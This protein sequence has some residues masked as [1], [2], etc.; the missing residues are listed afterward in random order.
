MTAAAR[1]KESRRLLRD[2]LCEMVAQGSLW[3]KMPGEDS[4]HDF[5]I[6]LRRCRGLLRIVKDEFPERD[7]QPLRSAL[8]RAAGYLGEV[9]DVDV[10]LE[11][12]AHIDRHHKP[13]G[14]TDV[15]VKAMQRQRLARYKR[16]EKLFTGPSWV[17]I[18]KRIDRLLLS[19]T[20]GSHRAGSH[21]MEEV[22]DREFRRLV[23]S[24][25]RTQELADATD[26]DS[27]HR[28]RTKL[29]RLRYFGRIMT[30]YVPKRHLKKIK[31]I[32]TCEQQLGRV[33][34]VDVTLAWLTRHPRITSVWLPATL[35]SVRSQR[36]SFFRDEWQLRRKKL[37][38]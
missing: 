12:V 14:K 18:Q 6:S 17:R 9:R 16:A 27:L 15:L 31:H 11:L 22:A 19:S 30:D 29:R 7:I 3:R 33:H 38:F 32:R 26:A 8:A 28:V 36:L 23:R 20:K 4:L 34:D 1:A 35:K 13:P 5:R 37:G 25:Q 2:A 21:S 10:M 24:V